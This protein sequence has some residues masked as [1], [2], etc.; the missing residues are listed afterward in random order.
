MK[1]EDIHVGDK[2]RIRQWDDMKKQFGITI[3]GSINCNCKFTEEMLPLCGKTA[4]VRLII[5]TE[6]L[7]TF[8]DC[9]SI[10]TDKWY[11][12]TDM[13]EPVSKEETIVIKSDGKTVSA[14]YGKY[15]SV[16]KCSP[17]DKFDLFVGATLAIA[18]LRTET[19]KEKKNPS[20]KTN[21]DVMDETF[22]KEKVS[23]FLD[24]Q[25]LEKPYQKPEKK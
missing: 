14:H 18:R 13:L 8:N 7:L 16:A 4:T 1:I 23:G 17:E 2:V 3:L 15:H 6:V 20:V 5:G 21:K 12:S 22:G 10:F 24:K 25:W 19:I 9:K 11:F